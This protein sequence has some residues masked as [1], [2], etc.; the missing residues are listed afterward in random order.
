MGQ[1][2]L[3]QCNLHITPAYC[4]I[5]FYQHT[6]KKAGEPEHFHKK[7][8]LSSAPTEYDREFFTY[9]INNLQTK[10]FSV[11]ELSFSVYCPSIW[12]SGQFILSK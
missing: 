2:R 5:I 3:M 7:H 1:C 8:H 6:Y 9:Q 10:L 12:N 4:E 11:L